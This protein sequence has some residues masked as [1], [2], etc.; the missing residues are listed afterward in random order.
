MPI[1]HAETIIDNLNGSRPATVHVANLHFRYPD[2]TLAL[3]GVSLQVAHGEKVALVGPNGAGKSTLMLH[4][5]GLLQGEGN[6]EV[7]GMPLT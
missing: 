6:V 3:N 2:G 4:L 7:A 5:N 1:Q